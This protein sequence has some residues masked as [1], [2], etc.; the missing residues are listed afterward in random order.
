[1]HQWRPV[2]GCLQEDAHECCL[3]EPAGQSAVDMV[4]A[5]AGFLDF[6]RVGNND[7]SFLILHIHKII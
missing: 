3:D 5:E 4:N 7:V 1:M 6:Y 2:A